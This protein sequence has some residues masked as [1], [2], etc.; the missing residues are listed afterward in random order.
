M[1]F[2]TIYYFYQPKSV[3]YFQ[4]NAVESKMLQDYYQ[5]YP[6]LLHKP[7]LKRPFIE[8][9]IPE[10]Q[11]GSNME[12]WFLLVVFPLTTSHI[13]CCDSDLS[14]VGSLTTG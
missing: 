1:I 14:D 10:S 5:L 7:L 11:Y 13:L 2:F 6:T 3:S 9:K 4:V 8:A 12:K